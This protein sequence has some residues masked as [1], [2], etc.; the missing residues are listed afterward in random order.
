MRKDSKED[1]V[2]VHWFDEWEHVAC[3]PSRSEPRTTVCAYICIYID[4]DINICIHIY[5]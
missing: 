5:I 4:I 2:L 1:A 3:D